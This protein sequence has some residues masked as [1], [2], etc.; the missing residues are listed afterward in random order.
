MN[1]WVTCKKS[2]RIALRACSYLFILFEGT[3]S[4]HLTWSI[5][6]GWT[7]LEWGYWSCFKNIL[8]FK[9]R[10]LMNYLIY[11]FVFCWGRSSNIGS[12]CSLEFHCLTFPFALPVIYEPESIDMDRKYLLGN[13]LV[14]QPSR[15]KRKIGSPPPMENMSSEKI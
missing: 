12:N 9:G 1:F 3:S 8:N 7:M 5:S 13:A 11:S 10:I 4:F 6:P 2:T 15:T 14:G